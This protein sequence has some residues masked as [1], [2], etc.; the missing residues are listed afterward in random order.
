MY[1]AAATA[2]GM[3]GGQNEDYV[4][5]TS[6]LLVLLDGAT[7]NGLALGVVTRPLPAET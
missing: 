6:D 7:V 5:A 3:H 4:A 2:Q 1:F